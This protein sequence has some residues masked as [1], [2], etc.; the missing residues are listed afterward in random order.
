MKNLIVLMAVIAFAACSSGGDEHDAT[1]MF[2][3]T[4][5]IVS[6]EQTGKLLYFDVDEGD[7]LAKGQQ[8][9]LVD[10]VQ[11]QLRAM[12]LGATKEAYASQRPDIEKQIAATRQQ[13]AKA[14]LEVKRYSA[15]VRDNAANRK[16][17]DDAESSVCV[18]RRQLD[19]QLS[20]LNNTTGS[21]NRQMD[22]AEIQRRQVID[23]LEKCRVK[24]PIGGTVLD[25]YAEAG[26]YATPGKPLFKI[27]DVA[28]MKL[29]AYVDAPR[30]ISLKVG[31]P[32]KVYADFGEDGNRE[33]KGVIEWI[34]D[35]A[36]FTPKTIQT[37]DER[38]NLV[39]AVKIAV[40]N[41]DGLIKIG[42]YGEVDF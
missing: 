11:L 28:D 8:V 10:T 30:L 3:A 34:S 16:Q 27:A 31:Q 32:V 24:S 4:E 5:V 13:L 26:E 18:L 39:Y 1:G 21:L 42:M 14:E 35:K 9:G 38:A 22:A 2:E 6:A 23:N 29:R 37:R 33:Y 20:Q 25:K 17:L 36:E 12:Q 15:L 40:K 7:V 41:T 19:A